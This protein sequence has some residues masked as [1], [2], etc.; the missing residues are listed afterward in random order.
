MQ[1]LEG[2]LKY[3][4]NE[5]MADT[6]LFKI[7]DL[8]NLYAPKFVQLSLGEKAKS[9]LIKLKPEIINNP[10]TISNIQNV[11]ISD[12]KAGTHNCYINDIIETIPMLCLR[13]ECKGDHRMH[14]SD[15]IL[16]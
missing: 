9:T 2:C 12:I 8:D 6:E 14:P 3:D 7:L 13:K 11:I 1:I 4:K 10:T 5:R 15:Y 16:H